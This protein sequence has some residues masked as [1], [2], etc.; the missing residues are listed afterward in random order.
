MENVTIIYTHTNTYMFEPILTE[1]LAKLFW[2]I[3]FLSHL[4]DQENVEHASKTLQFKLD[5]KT[6]FLVTSLF[7]QTH[8]NSAIIKKPSFIKCFLFMQYFP[9]LDA[10]QYLLSLFE[11][12]KH[13]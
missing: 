1:Q 7:G 11:Y 13:H 6:E 12:G 8:T 3:I 9:L 10:F 4:Q 5:L 2:R